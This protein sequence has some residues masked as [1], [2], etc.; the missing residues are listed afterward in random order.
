MTSLAK[1]VEML[2]AL[3]QNMTTEME[4]TI[5]KDVESIEKDKDETNYKLSKKTNGKNS[6]H[7]GEK[8]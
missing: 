7:S 5:I 8:D 4:R 2:K 3:V 6:L 1:E